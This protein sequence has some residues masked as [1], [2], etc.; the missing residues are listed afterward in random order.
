M[1]RTGWRA[2]GAGAALAALAATGP[3]WA[4]APAPP[5]PPVERVLTGR[6][7]KVVD[8]D[9]LSVR[10]AH[11]A[12][13]VH[14]AGV[15][16]PGCFAQPAEHA[17]DHLLPP[18]QPVR[19]VAEGTRPRDSDGRLVA[20][21]T[22]AAGGPS[23]NRA[24]LLSGSARA[25]DLPS[26]PAGLRLGRA[27]HRARVAGVGQW[28]RCASDPTGA[29]HTVS[30]LQRRLDALGY[31]PGHYR[32]K[33]FDYRTQQA[34]IAFQGWEGITRTGLLDETTKARL[35]SPSHPRPKN[36]GPRH[37]EI[38]VDRQVLLLVDGKR[39]V[40]AIHVSTGAGGRTPIGSFSVREKDLLSWSRP[41]Q[42]WMPHA[43]YFYG[44]FAMHAYPYVPA[45]PASH[46]CV[47][48]PQDE[49]TVVY[50]FVTLGTPV[51]V[52]QDLTSAT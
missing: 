18:G 39:V 7:L 45:Y 30:Q 22:R 49:A 28:A 4:A 34:L 25:L 24:L 50:D 38:S 46:G 40:R 6:V 41:F 48:L 35:A 13:A 1:R 9:T 29:I 21:V 44:G 42:V 12:T 11:H 10:I 52:R 31:L 26:G 23:A 47:R 32:T 14:L 3:A 37:V 2:A 5:G 17:L 43:A 16:A 27:A 36:P 51:L 33:V 8:G 19:L 15:S 20:L